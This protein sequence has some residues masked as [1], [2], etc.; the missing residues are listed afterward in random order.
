[1]PDRLA[2]AQD[3][4]SRL[5]NGPPDNIAGISAQRGAVQESRYVRTVRSPG[6]DGLPNTFRIRWVA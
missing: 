4:T 1:M 5:M 2:T 6:L 3:K